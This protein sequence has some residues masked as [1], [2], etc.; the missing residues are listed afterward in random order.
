ML[1]RVKLSKIPADTLRVGDCF[2]F[3]SQSPT[4]FYT[5]ISRSVRGGDRGNRGD[6]GPWGRGVFSANVIAL[7]N[8]K[9]EI[10]YLE[11]SLPVY[12]I[13]PRAIKV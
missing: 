11:P 8:G 7:P 13:S 9:P 5:V 3:H 10:W 4:T 6:I 1:L 2:C 12:L